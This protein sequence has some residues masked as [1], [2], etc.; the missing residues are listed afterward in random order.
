MSDKHFIFACLVFQCLLHKYNNKLRGNYNIIIWFNLFSFCTLA[1]LLRMVLINFP[2]NYLI[3]K[4]LM[5]KLIVNIRNPIKLS[6]FLYCLCSA[7]HDI[8]C[9]GP[10]LVHGPR[11]ENCWHRLLLHGFRSGHITPLNC[12][13][14]IVN[15]WSVYINCCLFVAKKPKNSDF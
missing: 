6:G 2:V 9:H 10:L 14:V 12:V 8:P 5:G 4:Q 1:K 11:V 13:R 7:A 3:I 15:P